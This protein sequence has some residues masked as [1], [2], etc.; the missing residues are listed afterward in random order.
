MVLILIATGVRA[1]VLTFAQRE[2]ARPG[3]GSE[4]R[5]PHERGLL[6]ARQSRGAAPG[7]GEDSEKRAVKVL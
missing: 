1:H 2:G 5:A 6:A 7:A 4:S 3:A